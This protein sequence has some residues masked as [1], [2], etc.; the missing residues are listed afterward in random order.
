MISN[1]WHLHGMDD[2]SESK[3]RIYELERWFILRLHSALTEDH[4]VVHNTPMLI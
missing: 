4:I 1:L 3:L 2:V